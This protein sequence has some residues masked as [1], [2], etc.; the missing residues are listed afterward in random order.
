LFGREREEV[1]AMRVGFFGPHHPADGDDR[2]S[3]RDQQLRGVRAGEMEGVDR[4]A[5]RWRGLEVV[6]ARWRWPV[7]V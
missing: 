2:W 7:N 6:L 1:S 3:G 5:P 4:G